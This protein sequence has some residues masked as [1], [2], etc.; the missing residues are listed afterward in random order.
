MALMPFA[1]GVAMLVIVTL[2]WGTTFVVVKEALATIP[3]PLL[4]AL[5]FSVT[6][7]AFVAVPFDRRAVRPALW[8]GLLAFAGFATQTIAL[9]TAGA[10]K[11][12]FI[13]GFAVILTPLISAAWFRNRVPV[14]G[15]VGG[16]LAL[17]G[18]GLL[19]MGGGEQVGGFGAGDLWALACAVSYAGYIVML[20]QVAGRANAF[21]LAGMQHLPMAA[22]AWVWAA[23]SLEALATTPLTTYAAIAYLAVVATG[24]VAVLQTYAQRVVPAYLAALIFVLEPVFASIFAFWLLGERLGPLGWLGGGLVVV[25]MLV[26]ELRRPRA[27]RAGARGGGPSAPAEAES[28]A[29]RVGGA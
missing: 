25:A 23:P 11:V 27:W 5:R 1:L 10:S 4:L 7:L 26:A 17:G 18:L 13:T 28:R 14:R 6:A 20:G 2:V 19:T 21:A 29:D 16:V 8:L 24:M 3:V 12:A 22:L 15:F 9:T